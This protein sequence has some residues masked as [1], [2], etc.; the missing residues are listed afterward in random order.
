MSRTLYALM[1]LAALAAIWQRNPLPALLALALGLLAAL[2]TLWSR[3][4]LA[5]VTYHRRLAASHLFAGDETDLTVEITNA[6]LLP[7]PW[8]RVE[9]ELPADV[10]VA[11]GRLQASFRP[12]RQVLVN[13]LALRYYERVRKQ[14]H[15]RAAR[16][17]VFD[18]GPVTLQAGDLFGFQRQ[19][20]VLPHLDQLVVYPR[21][22]PVAGLELPAGYPFGDAATHRRIT[23][24]PLAVS[25]ARDYV[26]GDNPRYI[27][28]KASAR[29]AA[30]QT[31]LF[32]PGAAPRTAIFLDVQTVL[33]MPGLV[34][35]YLE[36][37]ITAAASLVNAILERREA[38]GLYVN[39]WRRRSRDL[40][41]LP[42]S[43]RPEHG[44]AI[45]DAL[46]RV[47]DTASAPFD[48][49]VQAE[50]AGLP[51]GATVI[52][53]TATPT[54]G[55]YAALLDVRRAGHPTW[56]LAVGD[57][58]P[59]DVPADLPCT[60]LGGSDAW[61]SLAALELAGESSRSRP[62]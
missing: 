32:D 58:A 38:V 62:V 31:R 59:G 30:L 25:G 48:R 39:T 33:G 29:Y 36:Y 28:W 18:F 42:P 52:A 9:D 22:V 7:L 8:L 15:L 19:L 61:H 1:G 45:L 50:L 21:I 17:G 40:V 37:A 11:R 4:A 13:F 35:D 16:R 6:K 51:F 53:I 49:F 55:K 12:K 24:D 41:R 14:Y 34:E 26:P 44:F 56:L 5:N 47:H 23:D 27:H 43:R 3:Y 46:A 2:T 10:T 54:A 60:W 20:T 57:T